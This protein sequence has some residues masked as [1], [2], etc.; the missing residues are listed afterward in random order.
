MTE[1][2]VKW[3]QIKE[4]LEDHNYLDEE[5]CDLEEEHWAEVRNEVRKMSA[6]EKRKMMADMSKLYKDPD[7]LKKVIEKQ[8]RFKRKIVL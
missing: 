3:E 7:Y 4:Y 5:F 8:D 6:T 1:E 2:I